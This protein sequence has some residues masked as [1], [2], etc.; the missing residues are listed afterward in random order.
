[1][2]STNDITAGYS[3]NSGNNDDGDAAPADQW[4]FEATEFICTINKT[5]E[6]YG[7]L[8]AWENALDGDANTDLTSARTRAYKVASVTGT[9]A[10]GA[11]VTGQTNSYSATVLHVNVAG[12][13]PRRVLLVHDTAS[14][15]FANDEQLQVDAGNYVTL[16][17]DAGD[18]DD[19]VIVVAE[20]YADDGKLSDNLF[21]SGFTTNS[22]NY[23]K[24]TVP[25]GERHA[26]KWDTSKFYIEGNNSS[27]VIEIRAD[28]TKIHWVQATG[29][30][31]YSRTTFDLQNTGSEVAYCIGRGNYMIF[32]TVAGTYVYNC[33]SDK[34]GDASGYSFRGSGQYANCTS[35]GARYGVYH[36]ASTADTYNTLVDNTAAGGNAFDFRYLNTGHN[37][38]SDDGS[39]DS[40]GDDGSG[41][42][43]AVFSFVDAAGGDYH[44][45]FGDTS[46]AKDGGASDPFSGKY[47]DDIDGNNRPTGAWDI[48]ADEYT[49]QIYYSVGTSTA[50]LRTAS[51]LTINTSGEATFT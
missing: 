48:G 20:C 12:T 19:T 5:G 50:N 9:V 17:A 46:G 44:L 38:I 23:V 3:I 10:D 21:I 37:N 15:F 40:Y 4:I 7:S 51:N 43:N 25:E 8:S 13:G 30:S 28:Y 45:S 27:N 31:T 41:I 47:T 6:D 34:V 36:D 32:A 14:E 26:G 2:A 42:Q 24:I 35:I 22:T 18:T 11:T 49:K 39:A 29:T 1:A 16:A 33:L